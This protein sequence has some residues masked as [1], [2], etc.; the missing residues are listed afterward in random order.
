MNNII[1]EDY[2]KPFSN[3][4]NFIQAVYCCS[5]LEHYTKLDLNIII[6]C[7]EHITKQRLSL[8]ELSC[9]IDK[10]SYHRQLYP[11]ELIKNFET[12]YSLSQRSVIAN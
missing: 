11:T 2:V 7:I 8:D 3:F 1:I 10:I 6:N 9:F 5:K 4:N 12:S